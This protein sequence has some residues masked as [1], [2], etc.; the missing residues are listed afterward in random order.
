MPATPADA[1]GLMT[2]AIRDDNPVLFFEAMSLSHAERCEVPDGEHVEPIGPSRLARPGQDVTIAALGSM[3]PYAMSAAEVLAGE[4]VEAEII[5]V[6]TLRPWDPEILIAS[7]RRTNRL[8]I[9]HEAWVIGGFGAEIAATVA[10][11]VLG[12]LDAK[13]LRVGAKPVP[14]PS[15][16]LRRYAL[17]DR[18]AILAAVRRVVAGEVI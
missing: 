8:V 15:G 1:K 16:P 4:G 13:I 12:Y 2:A 11:E 5:D 10:E 6:R 9:V 18:E 3:V 7:V 14:I 17:P